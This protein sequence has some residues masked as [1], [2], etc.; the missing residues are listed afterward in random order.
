FLPLGIVPLLDDLEARGLVHTS[1]DRDA[2]AARLAAG[3]LTLYCGFD[4]SADSLHI[5][6]LVGLVTLRRFQR[7]RHHPIALAGGAT[8]MVGDPS[9][10]SEE[11]NLLDPETLAANVAAIKEQVSRILGPGGDWTLVDNADWT[12]DLRLLDFLREVGKHVTVNQMVHRESIRARMESEDGISFTE[13]SY[14]LLQA[15]DYLVLNDRRGCELQ[16]GGSDQW[17][18]IVAGIDLVRRKRGAAVH[19]LTWPLI[20]R[21]DG[22]TF[23]KTEEGTGW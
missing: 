19:G 15:H 16:L 4:P 6:N 20:T 7:H 22:R 5:G 9:G 21:A 1:T 12:R 13:F 10:K 2:L 18:N 11:R 23:G 14:M 3:S 8:G 17:G